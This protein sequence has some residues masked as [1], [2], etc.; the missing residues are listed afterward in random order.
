MASKI[1]EKL[2]WNEERL[3]PLR[4]EL[5]ISIGT[6]FISEIDPNKFKCE[7]LIKSNTAMQKSLAIGQRGVTRELVR[8]SGKSLSDIAENYRKAMKL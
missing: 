2:G 4:D 6:N 8:S 1:G 5:D 3:K 7:N